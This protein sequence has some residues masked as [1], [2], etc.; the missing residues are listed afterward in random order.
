MP[1]LP[2]INI[3]DFN[4]ELPDLHIAKYPLSERDASKLLVWQ[5]GEILHEQFRHLPDLLQGD[6]I[7]FFNNTKVIP[8]RLFFSKETGSLIETFLL[9]ALAGPRRAGH[10]GYWHDDLGLRHWQ[11]QTLERRFGAA[12][13]P[14]NRWSG[15][16]APSP[17]LRSAATGRAV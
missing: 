14:R 1:L 4:Y 5:Q 10:A 8:A 13:H 11:P 2:T 6:E 3:Q 7:L 15:S 12:P 17:P 9:P 16:A